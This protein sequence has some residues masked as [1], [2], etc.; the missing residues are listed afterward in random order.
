MNGPGRFFFDQEDHDLLQLIDRVVSQE[1]DD[2]EQKR[3]IEPSLHPR[4]IK[5]LSAPKAVRIALA[6]ASLMGT[7]EQGAASD[8][9][10]A[11]RAV[12]D[13]ALSNDSIT[14]RRNAARVLVQIIKDLVRASDPL[15]RLEMIHDFRIAA[16]GEPRRVRRLLAQYHLF[17]MPEAWNQLAFDHHVHDS[18]TKGR[19]TATHLVLDAWIKGIR[20]LTVVYYFHLRSEVASELLEAAEIMGIE[21]RIGLELSP[22]LRDTYVPL[23]WVPRGFH[24]RG[25]FLAFLDEPSTRTLME[26]GRTAATYH[27]KLIDG[28]LTRFNE[29]HLATFAA[30]LGRPAEELTHVAFHTFIGRGQPS[31]DQLAEFITE[32]FR[33][34]MGGGE[35][36]DER[37][38]PESIRKRY[39]SP[40]VNPGLEHPGVPSDRD[41]LPAL[42]RLSPRELI[43]RLTRIP[44][45]SR[46]TLNPSDLTAAEVL[47]VLHQS[48]GRIT[49]IEVF[50]IKDWAEGKIDNRHEIDLIRRVLNSGNVVEIKR[51]IQAMIQQAEQVGAPDQ[52]EHLRLILHDVHRLRRFYAGSRLKSRLASD[53]TGRQR[54]SRGMGLVVISTLPAQARRAIAKDARSHIPVRTSASRHVTFTE[55][56]TRSGEP[57]W[58]LR[59][60]RQLPGGRSLG[61]RQREWWTLDPNSTHIDTNGNVAALGGLP[62]WRRGAANPGPDSHTPSRRKPSLRYL[63]SHISSLTKVFLGFVPAFLTFFLTKDWWVLAWL[64]AP[65]WFGITG[66]RNIVQ[67]VLGGGGLR[68]SSLL[69]WN[70]FVSW[71]RVADSLLFTG[72]SVPLLDLLIKTL[73][74]DRGFGINAETAPTTLFAVMAATNGLYIFSHNLLRG[75]PSSAAVGNIFR[76]VLSIPLAVAISSGL[77]AA[78]EAGGL[79]HIE[80]AAQIQLWAAVISK[81]ASDVVAACIEGMAERQANLERRF[82]DY[83]RKLEQV[84]ETLDRLEMLAPEGDGVALLDDPV[85]LEKKL[86]PE[87]QLLLQQMIANALDLMYFAFYQPRASTAL[88]H[89]A[90]SL[91]PT[92]RRALEQSQRVLEL[93]RL[94]SI[95]L[96]DGFVGARFDH[97]LAFYLSSVGRYL[98]GLKRILA[99]GRDLAAKTPSPGRGT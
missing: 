27:A 40:E 9:L 96:V 70:D 41:D 2:T 19:K 49:Q 7:L 55:R 3:L 35:L 23:V 54:R 61:C 75:L 24:G 39:L 73:L 95:T 90:A 87:N 59:L 38:E 36:Q 91:S 76:S 30:E 88:R 82:H 17:E 16:S 34:R 83:R 4:G 84:R 93:R 53:S 45:G 86:G 92:E 18:T 6:V 33:D 43:D 57:S 78:L 48:E 29:H 67:A 66:M 11:L 46:I 68:R 47:E 13:E 51:L 1:T 74:L 97:A 8:R 28:L 62:A 52:A 5:E 20:E 12:R 60:L 94:I 89:L 63:N 21:A 32:T 44:S 69:R 26:E 72:F 25:D 22:R 58:L 98:A 37:L 10:R 80:A 15:Q 65:I 79:T 31:V 99:N 56:P 77:L 85:A 71:R 50:N 14:L 64:G 42:L 81:L